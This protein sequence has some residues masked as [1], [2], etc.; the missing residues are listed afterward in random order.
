[1][2]PLNFI[3]RAC[4]SLASWKMTLKADIVWFCVGGKNATGVRPAGT[5]LR[6]RASRLPAAGVIDANGIPPA[7]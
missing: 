3:P 2:L 1:M 5:K 6:A 7:T 4:L